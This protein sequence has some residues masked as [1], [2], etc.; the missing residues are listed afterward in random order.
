MRY[1]IKTA[2]RAAAGARAAQVRE[3]NALYLRDV[4][5]RLAR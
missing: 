4:A 5:M 2:R 3:R 1:R